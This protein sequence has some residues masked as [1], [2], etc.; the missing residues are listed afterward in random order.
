MQSLRDPLFRPD[1]RPIVVANADC[2]IGIPTFLAFIAVIAAVIAAV[3]AVVIG[4]GMALRQMIPAP[5]TKAR[6]APAPVVW[7]ETQE[8]RR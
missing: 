8:A 3:L 1:K 2:R 7:I 6:P 5:A 4:V